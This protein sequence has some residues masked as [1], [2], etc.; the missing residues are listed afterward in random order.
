ME[1]EGEVRDQLLERLVVSRETAEFMFHVKRV[2]WF[3]VE[4]RNVRFT[5]NARFGFT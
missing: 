4:R 2:F 1:S 5:W 3:H